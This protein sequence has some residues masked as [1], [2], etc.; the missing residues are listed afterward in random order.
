[1]R[2]IFLQVFIAAAVSGVCSAG[3][4]DDLSGSGF[5]LNKVAPAELSA[6][7]PARARAAAEL[8]GESEGEFCFEHKGDVAS[9]ELLYHIKIP[10]TFCVSRLNLARKE[11]GGLAMDVKGD[12]PEFKGGA[13]EYG[14]EDGVLKYAKGTVFNKT[15]ID[16]RFDDKYNVTIKLLA[17]VY[18][19]GNLIPGARPEATLTL[20]ILFWNKTD[21]WTKVS[22]YSKPLPPPTYGP[23]FTRPADENAEA[24]GMPVKFCVAGTVLVRKADGTLELSVAGDIHGQ[25]NASYVNNDGVNYVKAAIFSR[26]EG[27]LSVYRGVINI[28]VP[29]FLNGDINANGQV[30]VAASA[31]YNSDVYHL[32]WN[33]A[34]VPYKAG[35]AK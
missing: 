27:S 21:W 34:A 14:Y 20:G 22:Y 8:K 24:V 33:D 25:F 17:P 16:P 7:A 12:S 19:N 23:C 5:S 30:L 32:H 2:N 3:V 10:K 15:Y 13:A 28:F 9:L 18:P 6:P 11:D 35:P 26:E 31:G 4:M 29:A 1:M